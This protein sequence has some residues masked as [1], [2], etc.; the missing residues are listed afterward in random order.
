MLYAYAIHYTL[1]LHK[2]LCV[3]TTPLLAIYTLY[4]TLLYAIHDDLLPIPAYI[5]GLS[6]SIHNLKSTV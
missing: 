2:S 6:M 5:D 3:T 1:R 4:I